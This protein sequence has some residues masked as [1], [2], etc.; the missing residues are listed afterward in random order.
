[1]LLWTKRWQ[2]CK[3]EADED[4]K[5]GRVKTSDSIEELIIDLERCQYLLLDRESLANTVCH[6]LARPVCR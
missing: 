6:C 4:I 3:R 2:K 1:M 5:G